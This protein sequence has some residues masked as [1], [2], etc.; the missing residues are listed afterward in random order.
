MIDMIFLVRDV[1]KGI[2]TQTTEVGISRE[3]GITLDLG[4][5][6]FV[7]HIPP[8]IDPGQMSSDIGVHRWS[9]VKDVGQSES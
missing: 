8:T 3:R 5:S 1:T 2:Q 4:F 6:A 9:S 7:A